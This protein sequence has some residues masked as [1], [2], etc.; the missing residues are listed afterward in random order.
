MLFRDANH[1]VTSQGIGS[2]RTRRHSAALGLGRSGYDLR[3]NK[4]GG[5]QLPHSKLRQRKRFATR[6]DEAMT[7]HR[8]F[9]A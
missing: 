2:A 3:Q 4:T 7:E 6:R 9:H 1:S 5:R 8:R